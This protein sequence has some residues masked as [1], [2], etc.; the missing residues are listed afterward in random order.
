MQKKK[1]Q[2]NKFNNP[3]IRNNKSPNSVNIDSSKYIFVYG[4]SGNNVRLSNKANKKTLKL[5]EKHTINSKN[6]I[7]DYYP[8]VYIII[9]FTVLYLLQNA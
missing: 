9:I 6:T 8:L 5:L 7:K 3:Y 2:I 4:G 1:K